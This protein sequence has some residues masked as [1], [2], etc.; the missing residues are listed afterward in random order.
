MLFDGNHE[1]GRLRKEQERTDL[2]VVL[3][4][5]FLVETEEKCERSQPGQ[6]VS[7]VEF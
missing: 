5:Y 4:K 3:R 7:G 2:R 1:L 6:P